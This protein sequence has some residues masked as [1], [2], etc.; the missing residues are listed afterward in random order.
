MRIAV[1][2]GGI[3]GLASAHYLSRGGDNDV[4]LF[5]SSESLG[6]KIRSV[7]LGGLQIDTGPDAFITRSSEAMTLADELGLRENLDY[8]TASRA[9]IYRRKRLRKIPDGL[10]LGFPTNIHQ[11]ANNEVLTPLERVRTSI[12]LSVAK[13]RPSSIKGDD[14]GAILSERVG[15]PYAQ[16]ILDPLIGGI[17]AS[18]IWGASAQT[19][20][21]QIV[22]FLS[23]RHKVPKSSSNTTPI[24][25]SFKDGMTGFTKALEITLD[26]AGVEIKPGH[27]VSEI[28]L[29]GDKVR[30]RTGKQGYDLREFDKVI[31]AVPAVEASRLLAQSAMETSRLL[32]TMQYSSVTMTT[33]LIDGDLSHISP[34][35]SGV[36]VPRTEPLL[37]TAITF[38]SNKWARWRP[39]TERVL[40]VSV[41]RF[42]DTRH[43]SLS[44]P[45]LTALITAE[46]EEI[47]D[48][49]LKLIDSHVQPWKDSFVRFT[50]YHK[51]LITKTL[52]T[53]QNESKGRVQ[54]CGPHIFGSGIPSCIR[55][56]QHAVN[57][58]TG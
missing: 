40:R 28:D 24:F 4:V 43:L 51:D 29:N 18:S 8:P 54:M 58:V 27:E 52:S 32:S 31:L 50:P 39:A 13:A 57:S 14:L 33:M 55:S 26:K 37:T 6:G 41:G 45:E 21:P 11:I 34:D 44:G 10:M 16:N 35:I 46:V 22:A 1:V 5:E 15:K 17:N 30:L 3:S 23:G 2:G 38:G 47:L 53:V 20:A 36:L 49:R 56:A 42:G 12:Q 7:V 19:L 48:T 25:A 9:L